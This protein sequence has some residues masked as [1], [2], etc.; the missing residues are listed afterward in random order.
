MWGMKNCPVR[1]PSM[2]DSSRIDTTHSPP[3]SKTG[4]TMSVDE[5]T[6]PAEWF[7]FGSYKRVHVLSIQAYH[8]KTATWIDFGGPIGTVWSTDVSKAFGC[9]NKPEAINEAIEAQ[10]RRVRAYRERL[11]AKTL[12]TA[13]IEALYAP[14]GLAE[15]VGRA[16]FVSAAFAASS[17]KG[18]A[19]ADASDHTDGPLDDDD[20]D[21]GIHF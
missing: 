8:F 5:E 11:R 21:D 2:S 9:E 16:H 3:L 19:E 7:S 6:P 13:M 12:H 18:P 20:D 4:S 15:S 1:V 17:S 10:T 14:G